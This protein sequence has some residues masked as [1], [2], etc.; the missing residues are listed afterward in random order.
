MVFKGGFGFWVLRGWFF[1]PYPPVS[2]RMDYTINSRKYSDIF[3]LS[4]KFP[5][6]DAAI[7]R[8]PKLA[9]PKEK[10]FQKEAS[11]AVF[12]ILLFFPEVASL[13]TEWRRK[14]LEMLRRH[15]PSNSVLL[16]PIHDGGVGARWGSI[17]NF[18]P[19]THKMHF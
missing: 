5:A 13:C 16:P 12:F 4:S 11:F 1:R 3:Q 6:C 10:K 17:S 14:G 19:K 15:F 9:C 2:P 18:G 7:Q 8:M